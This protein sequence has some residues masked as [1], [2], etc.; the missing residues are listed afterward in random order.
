MSLPPIPNTKFADDPTRDAIWKRWLNLSFKNINQ[1]SSA[2]NVSSAAFQT[3]S[4]FSV[5]SHSHAGSSGFLQCVYT[6]QDYTVSTNISAVTA[7]DLTLVGTSQLIIEGTG[8]LV[9]V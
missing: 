3:S 7:E 6:N 2:A 5:S 4:Y 9:I 1:V 8:R